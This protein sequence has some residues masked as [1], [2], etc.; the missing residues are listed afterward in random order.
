MGMESKREV[1]LNCPLSA[2]TYL[3]AYY[4][5]EETE[6]EAGLLPLVESFEGKDLITP[7]AL[8]ETWPGGAWARH[9]PSSDAGFGSNLNLAN[10]PDFGGLDITD[11][12]GDSSATMANAGESN[13]S[14]EEEKPKSLRDQAMDRLL[15]V[16]LDP[17][18]QDVPA[19]MAEADHLHDLIPKLRQRLY[20]QASVLE[21]SG[22]NIV[23]LNKAFEGATIVDLSPFTALTSGHLA[24][25]VARLQKG[26][27]AMEVLNLSNMPDLTESDLELILDIG[28][29][30]ETLSITAILLLETPKISLDF[31]THHLGNH[32]V[33]HSELFRRALYKPWDS[34]SAFNG[35]NRSLLLPLQF[36]APESISQLV[37]IGISM[38][39]TRDVQ[40]RLEDGRFDWSSMK[41]FSQEDF[42]DSAITYLNF[43]LD[44]PVRL[45]KTMQSLRRLLQYMLKATS[46]SF[47]NCIAGTAHCFATTSV[48]EDDGYSVGPLSQTLSEDRQRPRSPEEESGKDRYLNPG[49]W[50]I[51]LIHEA[52]NARDQAHL[53]KKAGKTAF[54]PLKGVRYLLAQAIPKVDSWG[55][56][57]LIVDV[58]GYIEHMLKD[59]EQVRK[60]QTWWTQASSGFPAG[61]GYYD[62]SEAQAILDRVYS[63]E[64]FSTE[65]P[66]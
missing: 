24:T 30:S 17:S 4:V 45:G 28:N 51:V 56:Q 52:F 53:D 41:F 60:M 26:H 35:D 7:H 61:T 25:L 59:V 46:F 6:D 34:L 42:E 31:V 65:D 5:L 38:S 49:R 55:P 9:S 18:E 14:V 33:Y 20:N 12:P 19:L 8:L 37:L 48:L 58:P 36:D 22:A 62:E 43:P 44:I 63:K 21:P 57:Y 47:K 29:G 3:E 10:P 27:G 15:D 1:E 50:A 2:R 16:L 23:L 40:F 54:K 39:Q 32:D 66:V 64:G 13:V 11:V